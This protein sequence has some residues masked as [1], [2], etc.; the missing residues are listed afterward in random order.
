[1]VA[2]C[3]KRKSRRSSLMSSMVSGLPAVLHLASL[4]SQP[5][6]FRMMAAT[7]SE[8]VWSRLA[9]RVERVSRFF[10]ALPGSSFTP[11]LAEIGGHQERPTLVEP[12]EEYRDGIARVLAGPDGAGVAFGFDFA[13]ELLR[14]CRDKFDKSHALSFL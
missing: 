13:A 1:M 11:P 3:S 12:L 6:T 5:S 9:M 14:Q 10:R 4:A 7:E 8:S 2:R